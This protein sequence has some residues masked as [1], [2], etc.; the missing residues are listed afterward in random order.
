MQYSIQL[1]LLGICSTAAF[2]GVE[3]EFMISSALVNVKLIGLN[4]FSADVDKS[5]VWLQTFVDIY[6]RIFHT[7]IKVS[8]SVLM[9]SFQ[10]NLG[11]P[12]SLE[13]RMMEVM[14][15]TGAMRRAKLQQ[16]QS[17]RHQQQTSTQLITDRMPFLSPK[18]W[19]QSTKGNI[20][21]LHKK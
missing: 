6:R 20:P 13:L 4:P 12:V 19:R 21:H 2:T 10:V 11:Q 3:S 7:W 18:Q 16:L 17:N 14:V 1:A 8:L 5:Q 15:T 9:A